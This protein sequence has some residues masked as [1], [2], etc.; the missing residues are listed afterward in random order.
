MSKVFEI[1]CIDS[2]GHCVAISEENF[3]HRLLGNGIIWKKP[4]LNNHKKEIKDEELNLKLTLSIIET[5]PETTKYSFLV[6]VEGTD[7]TSLESF[8]LQLAKHIKE[9]KF[10][11]IYILKDDIS[12]ELTIQLYPLLYELENSLR[13]YLTIYFATKF[14]P[15]WWDKI[16][17]EELTKKVHSRKNNETIFSKYNDDILVDTRAFL[18]DFDDLGSIIYRVSA[19]NLKTQDLQKQIND[20]NPENNDLKNDII[21]LKENVK[22]NI[23]KYFPKF[24][25]IDF[26]KKWEFLYKIR[27]KIAHNSL[28]TQ[29]DFNTAK[30]YIDILLEFLKEANEELVDLTF[31]DD[32]LEDYQENLITTSSYFTLITKSEIAKELNLTYRWTQDNN[33]P[34]IGLR[35]FVVDILG[36][37]GYD[38]K[39]SYDL[40]EELEKDGYIEIYNHDYKSE[41]KESKPKA[42]KVIKPLNDLFEVNM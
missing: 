31:T 18:I 42:I 26:Q 29:K 11:Y 10:E 16:A 6:K 19:G 24:E 38:I 39:N 23:K 36:L 30:E 2:K 13:K 5:N 22:I 7:T 34:F 27:N 4:K 32:E 8:R 28:F 17:T 14:G 40:L 12:K 3:L 25:E 35:Y 1:A 37:K 15:K 33:I 20:L 21:K 9:E 41:Y